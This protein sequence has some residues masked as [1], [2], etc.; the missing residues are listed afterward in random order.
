M[1][2]MREIEEDVL[3]PTSISPNRDKEKEKACAPCPSIQ[4]KHTKNEVKCH[5][6]KFFQ[7]NMVL[8]QTFVSLITLYDYS[9][10]ETCKS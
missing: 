7:F 5:N 4:C 3:G 8:F 1:M 9:L 6:I 10:I 2:E